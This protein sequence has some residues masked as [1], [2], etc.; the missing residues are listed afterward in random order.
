MRRLLAAGRPG[1][2]ITGGIGAVGVMALF[3]V[4]VACEQA[5]SVVAT[6]AT[7]D[8]G[9]IQALWAFHNSAFTVLYVSLA[10]ALLGLSR[11]GVAAGL[12]P[13][14]F[15]RLAPVA[16]RPAR[17]RGDGRAVDR[18][19]RRPAGRGP[20][21]R[22]V[23]GLARL[24]GLDGAAPRPERSERGVTT[25]LQETTVDPAAVAAAA[26]EQA[27]R[28]WNEGDGAAFG[29]LF[30]DDTDF[31]D[32]RGG[33]HR[34]DGGLIGRGHQALFDSIYAGSVVRMRLDT[35]RVLAPGIVVAVATSRLEAPAG[36]LRG[37]NHSRM[38]A[39]IADQGGRWAITAFHNTLVVEG[40]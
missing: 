29:A 38:T 37:V 25:T 11:A 40:V 20:R 34:G 26:F 2:A 35:A 3:A 18:R 9:A 27:E 10:I 33:Q 14:A 1:W 21:G 4:V 24:P 22:R 19:R 7:P 36:P 31:V 32:I 5:L 23:R 39:V 15:E 8:L 17:P 6:S 16:G 28:A 30:A 13:R 12:T